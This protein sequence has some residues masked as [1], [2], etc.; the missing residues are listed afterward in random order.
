MTSPRRRQPPSELGEQPDTALSWWAPEPVCWRNL[1]SATAGREW[2]G[3]AEWVQFLTDRYALTPRTIPPCW[4]RHWPLVE[5][6]SALHTAWAT[7]Y[8]AGSPGTAPLDWHASFALTRE[9]LADQVARTG[10]TKDHHN[11][12]P[13]TRWLNQPFTDDF[14]ERVAQDVD[15]RQGPAA[16]PELGM[17]EDEG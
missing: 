7:A 8:A 6:L 15:Q 9:R 4:Y 5:E 17:S 11:D 10:C 16:E 12:D 2:I 14:I 1:D 3:L 13:H